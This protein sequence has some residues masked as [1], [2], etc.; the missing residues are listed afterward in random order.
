MLNNGSYV[1]FFFFAWN[2]QRARFKS[3]SWKVMGS[4]T[5]VGNSHFLFLPRSILL[6]DG[7]LA[8]YTEVF[9]CSLWLCM[10]KQILSR[11]TGIKKE[12]C[13]QPSI[14]Q[15]Q[16]NDNNSKSFKI[17]SNVWHLFQIEGLSSLRKC[18]IT[19][20]LPVWN[21][22]VLGKICVSRIVVNCV[23]IALY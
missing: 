11:A 10:K 13:G 1:W 16:L 20:Q 21:P 9:L 19:L 2:E 12:N 8:I 18:V 14:F 3:R 22:V 15:K 7:A 4:V 5:P 6:N 17:H 23:K